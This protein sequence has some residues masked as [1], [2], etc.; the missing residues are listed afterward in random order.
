[1]TLRPDG[2]RIRNRDVVDVATE[3]TV[4][5]KSVNIKDCLSR[6]FFLLRD[7]PKQVLGGFLVA[8]L[9]GAFLSG[10]IGWVLSKIPFVGWVVQSFVS[11]AILGLAGGAVLWLYLESSRG[12]SPAFQDVT[13]AVSDNA[14]PLVVYGIVMGL[15]S[16]LG[17]LPSHLLGWFPFL[18][19]IASLALLP[20][21]IGSGFLLSFLTFFTLPLMFD[22][23]MSLPEGIQGSAKLVLSNPVHWATFLVVN[24][25]LS[26]LII[27]IPIVLG[28][29][30]YAY[31]DV[32]CDG[33]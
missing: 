1:M 14:P 29:F 6:G 32:F 22:K 4:Y 12:K 11:G 21:V 26:C 9:G 13:T 16:F 3:L 18:A 27:P 28:A 20:I 24:M 23:G 17:Q 7:N 33:K 25:L 8:V 19:S 31:K 5:R 15:P 10:I 30:V 2:A